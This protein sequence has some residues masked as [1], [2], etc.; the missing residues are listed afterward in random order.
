MAESLRS[1]FDELTAPSPTLVVVNRSSPDPVRNL[2]DSLLDGQPVSITETEVANETDD[3]VALVEDGAVVARSTLDELLE[4]V[5]LI[6]SDLYKTGALDLGE[7]VLPDVLRGLDEVPFRLRGYPASNKEK[8]LLIIVSRVIERIAAEHGRGTLRASFQRLSRIND[9][10]GTRDVYAALADTD[11]DVH[12][13]GVGDAASL[14]PLPVT[15]HTGTSFPYRR[16]WFVVFT[17][18]ADAAGDRVALLALEDEPNVW[19][20]FWTFRPELV[21]RIERHI[22]DRL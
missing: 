14:S 20:G 7:V 19:D 12:V 17:P 1:F 2:L 6:N 22:A 5:L 3:V 21:D 8:L 16:S 10:R 4:S 18:P 9:E 13:Y 11:V 15:V